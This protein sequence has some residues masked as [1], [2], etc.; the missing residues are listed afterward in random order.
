M[1]DSYL[2]DPHAWGAGGAKITHQT[3]LFPSLLSSE[4]AFSGIVGSLVQENP[5][6]GKPSD[7]QIAIVLL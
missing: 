6:A 5:P 2:L 1:R 4:G 7:P 3:E